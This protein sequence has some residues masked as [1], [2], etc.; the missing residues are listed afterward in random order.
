M[1][2][3][4]SQFNIEVNENDN[5]EILLFN[6]YSSQGKWITKSEYIEIKDKNNI[7]LGDVPEY[8][9]DLGFIIPID[10]D[11]STY[12]EEDHIKMAY[13]I[14]ILDLTI[15]VTGCCNYH[16]KYCFEIS[17]DRHIDLETDTIE[18]IIKFINNELSK[19]KFKSIRICYFGGEPLLNID[20]IK[21]INNKIRNITQLPI[22]SFI[23]T[24]GRY[25]NLKTLN[26]LKECNLEVAQITI[27]GPPKEYAYIKGCSE[28]DFYSVISNIKEIQNEIDI[29][30]RIH[31]G[32]NNSESV[33]KLITYLCEEKIKCKIYI[34]NIKYYEHDKIQFMQDYAEYVECYKD[35]MT[36]VFKNGY[37]D[38]FIRVY[39]V[40][41]CGACQANSKYSFTIDTKGNLYKCMESL[42]N[43]EFIIGNVTDGI[44]EEHI[45]SIYIDNPLYN[46]CSH[47]KFRPLCNGICTTDRLV[48][49]KGINCKALKEWLKYRIKL[50]MIAYE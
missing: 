40:H 21:D 32:K 50:K 43:K 29:I 42:F 19:H 12:L 15:A 37:E 39:P 34:S 16:C 11:E 6:T 46:E 31:V 13:G 18:K 5:N 7:D 30:I 33:K 27:D 38:K 24:N 36:F 49:D 17:N 47:C 2:Y 8:L 48:L 26:E 14:D 35:I 20:G 28:N 23:I 41:Q 22:Y 44:T 4:Y 45:N 3:K 1:N 10:V 25:L 9:S